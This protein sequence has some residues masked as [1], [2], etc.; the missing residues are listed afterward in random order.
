M[1]ERYEKAIIFLTC[2]LKT[3]CWHPNSWLFLL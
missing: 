3:P 2:F 1:G